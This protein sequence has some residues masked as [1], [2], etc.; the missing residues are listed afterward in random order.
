MTYHDEIRKIVQIAHQ[1]Y[2]QKLTQQE[3]AENF[4]ISRPTI[5][6]LL[7]TAIDENIVSINIIDPFETSIELSEK[8]S[9]CLSLRNCVVVPGKLERIS[10]IRRNIAF[11]A[12]DY[13]YK[14][15]QPGDLIGVGWGRTLYQFSERIESYPVENVMFVP[16]LGG[17]GQ[18]KQSLQVHNIIQNISEAFEGTWV[19]YHMPGVLDRKS[20]RDQLLSDSKTQE[21]LRYWEN[22]TKAVVGIGESPLSN[23]AIFKDTIGEDECEALIQQDAVGDICMRFYNP[24]GEPVDYKNLGVMS[25][26]LSELVKVPEVIAVAGGLQKV[27]A[28]IGASYAKY[29]TTLITDENTALRIIEETNQ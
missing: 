25:I 26:K 14:E 23:D 1:Y 29:I 12:I 13:L 17:I 19:Q 22:M 16:L 28:I 27:K 8:L 24:D 20:I 3:I 5:A 6:K 11:A 10:I 9:A 18:V 7:K 4:G 15:I 21:M 2:E